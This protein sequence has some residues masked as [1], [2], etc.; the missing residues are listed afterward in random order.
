MLWI[1]P[2]LFGAA[3]AAMFGVYSDP[4]CETL[5]IP[6]LAFSDVCTWNTY[7]QSYALYLQNCSSNHLAVQ[8]FNATD[9]PTCTD[10]PMNQTFPVSHVCEPNLGVYTRILDSS[11]CLGENT[12]FNIVAHDQADCSDGGLPFSL[13]SANGSCVENSFAPSKPP[14]GWDTRVFLTDSLFVMEVYTSTDGSCKQPLGDFRSKQ[15]GSKCLAP[16]DGFY[17]STFMQLYR[18]FPLA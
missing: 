14:A 16:V 10:F 13:V 18:A 6:V 2:L 11:E 8:I 3:S 12:T 9:S 4:T 5:V 1:L 7:D 15:Y 17:N